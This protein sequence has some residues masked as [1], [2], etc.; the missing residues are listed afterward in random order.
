MTGSASNEDCRAVLYFFMRYRL[1]LFDLD[2]TLVDTSRD[3]SNALNHALRSLRLKE[4]TLQETVGLIGEGITRL[5]EKVLEKRHMHL[6]DELKEKFIAYYEE[7]LV[8]FSSVY[9]SV[10]ETLVL[11]SPWKKAVISNKREILSKEVLSKTGL[12]GYFELVVGSDTAPEKKPSP[13]PISY[14]LGN[15]GIQAEQALLVGDSRYDIEAGKGAG[16]TTVGVTYGYGALEQ[17]EGADYVID[18]FA[19]LPGLLDIQSE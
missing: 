9:P 1:L 11:L 13:V 15:F 7:H 8:D 10:Q 17:I 14:A 16:V 5:V 6:K 3:I 12:E 18:S 2:G 19:T 4:L